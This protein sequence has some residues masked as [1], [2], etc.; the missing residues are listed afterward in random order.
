MVEVT[1]GR[2][3]TGGTLRRYTV[4]EIEAVR[5]KLRQVLKRRLTAPHRLGV[6][7][8]CRALFDPQGWLAEDGLE[9]NAA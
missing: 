9:L 4:M 8:R 3:G 2:I 5:A 7:Y 1:F 6:A